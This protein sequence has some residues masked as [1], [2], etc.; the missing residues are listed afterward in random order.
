MILSTCYNISR[1]FLFVDTF[2]RIYDNQIMLI[3]LKWP[4]QSRTTMKCNF[5]FLLPVGHMT[6][7]CRILSE[8]M[9]V[10]DKAINMKMENASDLKSLF[11][12]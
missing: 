3:T 12:S 4:V 8:L 11:A 10:F 9:S 5:I 7:V 6:I 1:V 2:V